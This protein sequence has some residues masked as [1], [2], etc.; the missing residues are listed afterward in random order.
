MKQSGRHHLAAALEAGPTAVLMSRQLAVSYVVVLSFSACGPDPELVKERDD[1]AARVASLE[2]EKARLD[3]EVERLSE[4]DQAYWEKA[5]SLRESEQWSDLE[6]T[7]TVLLTRWPTT[8]LKTEAEKLHQEVRET[9]ASELYR[10]A[11]AQMTA[12]G[13]RRVR[14]QLERIISDYGETQSASLA[15]ADLPILSATMENARQ[16]RQAEASEARERRSRSEADL[17]LTAFKWSQ[18]GTFATVEGMVRNISGDRL[19][20]VEAVV[21]FT[22]ANRDFV[23]SDSALIDYN[24]I[25]ANQDSPFSVIVR[26]NPAMRSSRV[27][28]KSLFGGEIRTYHAWN[29]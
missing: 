1:L 24:P 27:E 28:F 2:D 6:T 11:Q 15:R 20:N 18:N 19:E 29:K 17:E 4:T 21:I 16:L 3:V 13:E 22:D 26:Y 12:D 7:L 9:R 14:A 8:A 25:L 10:Q 5:L 23:T